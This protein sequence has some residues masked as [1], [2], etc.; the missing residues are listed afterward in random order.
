MAR[1]IASMHVSIN[2]MKA[3]EKLLMREIE[4]EKIEAAGL[5]KLVKRAGPYEVSDHALVRYLERVKG[6]DMAAL[7]EEAAAWAQGN[8]RAIVHRGALVTILPPANNGSADGGL[9]A[10]GGE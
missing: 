10:V 7:R 9:E 5:A 1:V 4:A 8:D 2:A 3:A 6:M